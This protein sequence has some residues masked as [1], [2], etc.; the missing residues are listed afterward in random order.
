MVSEATDTPVNDNAN[1]DKNGCTWVFIFLLLFVWSRYISSLDIDWI[2]HHLHSRAYSI[3]WVSG[4]LE[5]RQKY[6][7]KGQNTKEN[8]RKM[9]KTMDN[10]KLGQFCIF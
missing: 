6:D 10:H 1:K 3:T 8:R 7:T 4:V 2:N 5:K 9:V